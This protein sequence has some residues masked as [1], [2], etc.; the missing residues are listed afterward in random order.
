[1]DQPSIDM[2]RLQR[3]RSRPKRIRR[4][5]QWHHENK[6]GHVVL[7]PNRNNNNKQQQIGHCRGRSR[8]SP[9]RTRA[10]QGHFPFWKNKP[11]SNPSGDGDEQTVEDHMKEVTD[12]TRRLLWLVMRTYYLYGRHDDGDPIHTLV[13]EACLVDG[14]FVRN[15]R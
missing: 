13:Q 9:V 12:K 14:P 5:T 1:V 6:K 8:H 4:R 11:I 7:R 2:S 10:Q 15:R 3:S